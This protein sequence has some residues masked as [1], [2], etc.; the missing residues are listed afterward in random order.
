MKLDEGHSRGAN[1]AAPD[2]SAR[3]ASAATPRASRRLGQCH[4]RDAA[5]PATGCLRD[6]H[7]TQVKQLREQ[8]TG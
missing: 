7:R 5:T 2:S 3:N 4:H 1:A 8:T 6:E